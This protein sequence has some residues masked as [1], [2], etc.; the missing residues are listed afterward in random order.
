MNYHRVGI[1]LII[2]FK[3]KKMNIKR[4]MNFLTFTELV[5]GRA[6]LKPRLIG[7]NVLTV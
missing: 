7:F 2:K 6:G 1:F 4:V 3:A 5:Q